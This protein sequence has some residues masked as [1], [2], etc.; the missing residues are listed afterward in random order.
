LQIARASFETAFEECNSMC[1]RA[2]GELSGVEKQLE[3]IE[4][5]LPALQGDAARR[6]SQ[7]EDQKRLLGEREGAFAALEKEREKARQEAGDVRVSL[8]ELQGEVESNLRQRERLAELEQELGDLRGRRA[9]D[10][11]RGQ[12]DAQRY[13]AELHGVRQEAAAFAEKLAVARGQQNEI[14]VKLD[15]ERSRLEAEQSRLAE[16]EKTRREQ[17]GQLHGTE[18]KLSET[19]MRVTNLMERMQENYDLD[20]AALLELQ[21]EWTDD[22]P[23]PTEDSVKEL[24]QTL[25][26]LGPVNLLALDEFEEKN[27][28]LEFLEAQRRDLEQASA[29]LQQTIEKINRTARFLFMETFDQ[30]STNFRETIRTVFGGGEGDLVLSNPED[31]LD[32]DVEIRV[33]PRGKKID[34]LTQLSSGERT[35]TAIALLFSIYLV[36]PSPFCIFDEVD[37]P[38]DDANIGRFVNLLHEFRDRTQFIVITHNKLTM[39]AADRLYGVTMEEEGVSKLVTVALDGQVKGAPKKLKKKADRVARAAALLQPTDDAIQAVAAD[40]SVSDL[41]GDAVVDPVEDAATDDTGAG[42]ARKRRAAAKVAPRSAAR[43]E[44]STARIESVTI[45]PLA[46]SAE[47][48][49]EDSAV[50]DASTT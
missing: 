38:L 28:R 11:E 9:Q 50:E 39:E 2:Q 41:I 45:E 21:F 17:E 49:T 44:P 36:K 42:G 5:R 26:R 12:A 35:L 22:Q 29:S 46:E 48:S 32:S 24:R 37:A 33:R 23:V 15:G 7:S 43:R 40:V 4:D 34:T 25:S 18:M 19:R 16:I 8:V 10:V 1:G 30:V 6:T 14:G 13:E 31:P 47:E 27:Q 20:E 3:A